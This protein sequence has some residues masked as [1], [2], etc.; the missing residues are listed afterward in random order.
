MRKSGLYFGLAAV[1]VVVMTAACRVG[2]WSGRPE[3][4]STAPEAG[5]ESYIIMYKSIVAGDYYAL[6]ILASGQAE[7]T[8]HSRVYE[9]TARKQGD[10]GP[11]LAADLFSLLA[12]KGFFELEEEYQLPPPEEGAPEED[13]EDAYYWV[14]TFD[15]QR[16]KTVLSHEYARPPEL[17]EITQALFDAVLQLPDEREEGAFLLALDYQLMPYLRREEGM[18]S[19][20]LDDQSVKGYPP[21][22]KALHNPCSLVQI[23]NLAESKVGQFFTPEIHMMEVMFSD[24]RFVVL[25]LTNS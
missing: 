24:K 18:P 17:Q 8:N 13:I 20:E 25:L 10:L 4:S 19:L 12:A 23:E 9:I 5:Q 22:E 1:M 21:L 11:E 16:E 7:Y 15:G 2:S 3:P 14:A 6:R